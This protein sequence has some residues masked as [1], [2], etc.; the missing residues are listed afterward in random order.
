LPKDTNLDEDA[1]VQPNFSYRDGGVVFSYH[2][3]RITMGMDY[4]I[5]IKADG[6]AM[7]PVAIGPFIAPEVSEEGF[8]MYKSKSSYETDNYRYMITSNINVSNDPHRIYKLNKA[9]GKITLVNEKP[10]E[11]FKYRNERLYFISDDRM[12]YSLSLNDE[13][14]KLEGSE[15]VYRENYEVLG[16]NIY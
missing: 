12:L 14:I 9:T 15:P 4:E 2:L 16:K 1:Y 8:L 11:A 10:A 7:E 6:T 13:T 5:A 3:G